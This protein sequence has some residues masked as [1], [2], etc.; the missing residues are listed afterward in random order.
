MANRIDLNSILDELGPGIA[1]RAAA[2]DADDRF[3]SESYAALKVR[4]V[5]SA[6]VPE[7]YGGGGVRHSAMCEFLRALAQRCPSTALA[8]SMHQHLVAAAV[9]NDRAGRPGRKLLDRVAAGEAVLV[10]TG[11]NDWLE[12]ERHHR[13]SR[14]RIPRQ[15]HQG[16]RQRRADG[17]PAGDVGRLGG[18]PGGP[19]GD[20]L[21]AAA[22]DGG[23]RADGRLA[24]PRHA[25]DGVA[26]G[27]ARPRV[28]ARGGDSSAPAARHL[29]PGLLRDRDRRPAAGHVC[30]LTASPR[31]PR[32]LP[33]VAPGRDPAIRFCRSSWARWRTC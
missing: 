10:S 7:A 33:W 18:C 16:V 5:F 13:A 2:G 30:L 26:H 11:A 24:D 32:R 23:G 17:R 9:A 1:E 29:P 14:R 4:R 20:P 25:G 15:R 21:P 28:R 31:P 27:Q 8:L 22:E 12:F 6:L 19:A 3:V